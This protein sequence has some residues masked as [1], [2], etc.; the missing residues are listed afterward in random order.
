MKPLGRA[1]NSINAY[2]YNVEGLAKY[3]HRSPD[4]ISDQE[5]QDYLLETRDYSWSSLSQAV[6]GLRYF[7]HHT[8][9]KSKASFYIPAPKKPKK[10]PTVLSQDEVR[11]L[12]QGTTNLRDLV[13][14]MT[15][16]M[17]GLR[18]IEVCRL[19]AKNIDSGM[20][21]IWVRSGK[22][23]K[24]RMTLLSEDLLPR[25]RQYWRMYE[26]STWLFPSSQKP[27]CPLDRP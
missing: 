9:G 11:R 19:Q 22:G 17:A 8:L 25:L 6:H 20:N 16:Y 24:D 26:L 5:V 14:L 18:A 4:K 21:C 23:N 3:Y 2:L 12:Y 10:L 1:D 7:Y 13:F 15:C 27:G